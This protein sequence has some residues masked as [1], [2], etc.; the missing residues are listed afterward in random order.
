MNI[1]NA[2]TFVK[3]DKEWITKI[4][5]TG[6]ISII[7]L[8]GQIYL[9]GW[10]MEVANRY[11][12]GRSDL[13]PETEFGKHIKYGFKFLVVNFVYS[14]PIMVISFFSGIFTSIFSSSESQAVQA[15]GAMLSCVSG[16]F[17]MIIGLIISLFILAATLRLIETGNIR[18]ALDLGKIWQMLTKAPKTFLVLLLLSILVS[19]ISSAGL[20]FCIVGIIFTIPYGAAVY[21][22][23]LGQAKVEVD[24][25]ISRS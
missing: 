6:L 22:H 11:L 10:G 15:F 3:N 17:S 23:L 4:L 8:I 14:L 2:F 21:G 20:I 19:L 24:Q 16:L 13:L 12:A 25:A 1:S 7:P 5:I 18:D 9:T